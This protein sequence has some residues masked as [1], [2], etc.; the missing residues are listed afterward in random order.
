MTGPLRVDRSVWLV[1]RRE[2]GSRV[3]SRPV[4]VCTATV[5]VLL[6][7]FVLLQAYVFGGSR[8]L[9]IGLAGQASSLQQAL[10]QEMT[11]LGVPVSVVPLDT[12]AEGVTQ[13]SDGELDVLV[14]GARSALHVTVDNHLD[15]R[16]RATLNSQV[17]QQILDA[18]LA[19]LGARP[20]DVLSKV[21]QAQI[22][23]TQLNITDPNAGQRRAVG[24]VAGLLVALSLVLFPTLVARRIAAD[25]AE[26]TGEALLTVLRPRR[27][28]AGN[29][30]GTGLA[31]LVHVAAVGVFATILC[32]LFGISTVPSAVLVA[33][34]AGLVWFAVGYGLY[35]TFAAAAAVLAGQHRAFL[36]VGAVLVA[37]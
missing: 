2:Y 37:V 17:R 18:Q 30:G 27:L 13:V 36:A 31:G 11:A 9:R 3:R 23:V 24:V 26:G 6:L 12:V 25:T 35:G 22:S 1:T 33:L 28:L 32:M 8:T 14:Y 21:D 19:Q 5:A 34:V 7:A 16:L 10:P 29:L 15:P 20:D 4:L